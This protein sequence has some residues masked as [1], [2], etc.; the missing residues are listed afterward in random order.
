M[1]KIV[2]NLQKA[3]A[4]VVL[5][6][7]RGGDLGFRMGQRAI[8]AITKGLNSPE[9]KT[10]MSLFADNAA[11]L[12]RLTVET[13]GEPAYLPQARAYIVSNAVCDAA[14]N[15]ETSNRVDTRIDDGLN[16]VSDGTID[17]LRPFPIPDV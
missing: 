2:R 6:T 9:W 4:A 13:P 1:S 14:T 15:T 10:Y 11:Q 17:A 8:K 3:H 5:D 16:D 7:F 12:N